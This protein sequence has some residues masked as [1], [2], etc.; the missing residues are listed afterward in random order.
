MRWSC[1]RA[2]RRP[3]HGDVDP[4]LGQAA[5][6]LGSAEHLL[7]PVDRA[8]E[9]LAERVQ[10]DAGLAVPH[11]AEREL[12]RALASQVLDPDVLD[13]VGRRRG[14]ERGQRVGL[15]RLRVHGG[16]CIGIGLGSRAHRS[17]SL[18][19][20]RDGKPRARNAGGTGE[21]LDARRCPGSEPG[22][23]KER[24]ASDRGHVLED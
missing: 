6:E 19:C 9:A 3:R 20:I 5:V 18:A 14:L 4:L 17:S 13:L 15:E 22:P 24:G 21:W 12:E 8:L 7:A 1:P 16:D 23:H 10:R 2:N 11:V